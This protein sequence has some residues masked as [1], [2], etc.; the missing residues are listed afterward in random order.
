MGGIDP[1]EEILNLCSEEKWL[2][3]NIIF[4]QIQRNQME[5]NSQSITTKALEK[6]LEEKQIY[7]LTL[8]DLWK[9]LWKKENLILIP[10][11]LLS[12][13]FYGYW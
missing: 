2:C 3:D 7:R 4:H 8:Y 11:Y 1:E 9:F 6:F 13:I 5:N 12:G 10:S